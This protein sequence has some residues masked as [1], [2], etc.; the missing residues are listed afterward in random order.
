[1]D[2]RQRVQRAFC[3]PEL[4][5]APEVSSMPW[6]WTVLPEA[7]DGDL[8]DSLKTMAAFCFDAINSLRDVLAAHSNL[9]Q[10][11]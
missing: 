3:K 10:G 8:S 11:P 9:S 4:R 1:M 7:Q 6:G 5:Q 2:G